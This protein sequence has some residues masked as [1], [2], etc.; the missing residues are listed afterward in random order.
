M[1]I[2]HW[3]SRCKFYSSDC[4]FGLNDA[5][6][7]MWF[8]VDVHKINEQTFLWR[9][10]RYQKKLC[11]LQQFE[12]LLHFLISS[13]RLTS[14]FS[15]LLTRHQFQA[16]HLIILFHFEREWKMHINNITFS[17]KCSAKNRSRKTVAKSIHVG[18]KCCHFHVYCRQ[19]VK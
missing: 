5:T 17:C 3:K 14:F 11:N 10:R 15:L 7:K 18:L 16:G 12:F 8:S 6:R 1:T 2:Q 19:G 13:N 4:R 9:R